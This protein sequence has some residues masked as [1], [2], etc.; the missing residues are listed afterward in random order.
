MLLITKFFN[1]FK[2]IIMMGFSI[3]FVKNVFN[4]TVVIYNKG[5]SFY[6]HIWFSKH[7]FLAIRPK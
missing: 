3:Y 1:Y 5:Y 4:N 7:F 2:N 6:S